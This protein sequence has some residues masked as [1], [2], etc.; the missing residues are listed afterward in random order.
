MKSDVLCSLFAGT[1]LAI[2]CGGSG[3]T[4]G[5]EGCLGWFCSGFACGGGVC[6]LRGSVLWKSEAE[7]ILEISIKLY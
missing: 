2:F 6:R 4:D 7:I 5:G 1:C 3:R